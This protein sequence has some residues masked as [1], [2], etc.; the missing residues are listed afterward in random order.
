M[1]VRLKRCPKP[2]ELASRIP[3]PAK[4][5]NKYTRGKLVIVAGSAAYPGAACLSSLAAYRMGAGYV[6]VACSPEA[7]PVLHAFNPNVVAR[8]W[9]GWMPSISGFAKA[10]AEHPAACLI[11][12]GMTGDSS[13]SPLILEVMRSCSLPLVVDGGAITVLASEAG[14]LAASSRSEAGLKTIVTP[15]FGEAARLARP[16]GIAAPENPGEHRKEDARFA[17]RLA[18][19][20]GATV[21][22]KGSDTFIATDAVSDGGKDRIVRLM[23]RGTPVL[24]R[25]GTGDVLSGMVGSL[26]AQGL[27]PVCAAVLAT[28]LHAEAGREAAKVLT[29]VS[30]CATDVAECIPKAIA[31]LLR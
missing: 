7:L 8:S 15:H 11:G 4:D 29:E 25:A 5:A 27:D 10:D 17:Q 26:L 1:T 12:P 2:K 13:E 23:D 22:L 19:L 14:R 31:R 21:V 20:Y 6:E 18:L 9:K 24:A 30:A 16:F 3:L 28:T